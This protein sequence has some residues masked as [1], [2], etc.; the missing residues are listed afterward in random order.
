MDQLI[1]SVKGQSFT[2]QSPSVGNFIDLWKMRSILS[3]GNYGNIYRFGM[4]IADEA[5]LMID[6]ESFFTVFCPLFIKSLKSGSIRELGL[7]DYNELKE[8][9]NSQILPWLESIEKLMVHKKD[10]K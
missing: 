6:I 5:L 1:F 4:A 7:E 9:Y 10:D 2:V 8:V 3:S